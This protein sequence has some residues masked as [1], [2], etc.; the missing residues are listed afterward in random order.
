MSCIVLSIPLSSELRTSA[1]NVAF[2]FPAMKDDRPEDCWTK[3][4]ECF[5]CHA[6][7]SS[8]RH[9]ATEKARSTTRASVL[10]AG[11]NWHVI[12]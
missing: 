6:Q 3:P 1:K 10:M 8:K 5:L 4:V 7:V 12:M 9:S 2:G 11:Y